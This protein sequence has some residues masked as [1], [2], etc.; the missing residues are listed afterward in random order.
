MMELP[1][2][3]K[4]FSES[5]ESWMKIQPDQ[6]GSISRSKTTADLPWSES[7]APFLSLLMQV[8]N[9]ETSPLPGSILDTR[10]VCGKEG[11]APPIPFAI[12]KLAS[13]DAG[14][15]SLDR[16]GA[17]S[18]EEIDIGPESRGEKCGLWPD[19]SLNEWNRKF[20]VETHNL[21]HQVGME[22]EAVLKTAWNAE[23]EEEFFLQDHILEE[24]SP[25]K[26]DLTFRRN[27]QVGDTK[28]AIERIL[29]SPL[30]E[31]RLLQEGMDSLAYTRD[32]GVPVSGKVE[33]GAQ[34]ACRSHADFSFPDRTSPERVTDL[35]ARWQESE[36]LK[37]A[38]RGE[39]LNEIVEK[40]VLMLKNGQ[41]VMRIRLKP[42]FLG[43]L[44]VKVTAEHHRVA[45]RIVA[46][47]PLVKDLIENNIALL[48]NSLQNQG[49]EMDQFDVYVGSESHQNQGWHESPPLTRTA[50][51]PSSESLDGTQQE[52]EEEKIE[53]NASGDGTPNLVNFF[54]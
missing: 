8:L 46:E 11:V 42:E 52:T 30:K 27:P 29:H 4:D 34:E 1:C 17:G 41:K 51:E 9:R 26:T 18:M 5:F 7:D 37:T 23:K 28:G 35:P 21:A 49:L 10:A 54:V 24:E 33:E 13:L 3:T 6:S 22:K 50:G 15:E 38:F 40:A 32:S 16:A 45:L 47:N 25:G 14:I 39:V 31:E 36:S 48:K 12:L 53:K 2:V 43:E 20:P 19:H 44:Q